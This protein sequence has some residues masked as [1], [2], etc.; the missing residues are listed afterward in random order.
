MA[1]TTQRLATE[2]NMMHCFS[3]HPAESAGWIPITQ[4]HNIQVP[5]YRGMS[6]KDRDL[7]RCAPESLL[8]CS[9]IVETPAAN[10]SSSEEATEDFKSTTST[11]GSC[12]DKSAVSEGETG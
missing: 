11:W 2:D 3:I 12:C 1:L 8:V 6:C 10:L 7:F 5:P 9:V 4:A